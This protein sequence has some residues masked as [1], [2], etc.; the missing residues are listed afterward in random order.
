MLK[1]SGLYRRHIQYFS[2]IAKIL[3]HLTK[4]DVDFI[5]TPECQGAFDI[6]CH[7][8]MSKPIS[9]NL[10]FSEIFILAWDENKI[11]LDVIL[12]Q[13]NKRCRELLLV[14][15]LLTSANKKY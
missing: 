9:A 11:G 5:R 13:K 7:A 8:L 4:N 6:L 15:R 14:S 10:D 2:I 3:L 1:F 12:S